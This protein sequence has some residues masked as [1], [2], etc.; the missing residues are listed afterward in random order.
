MNPFQAERPRYTLKT[1][2]ALYDGA[3][4]GRDHARGKLR[5]T[6]NN[7]ATPFAYGGEVL[8]VNDGRIFVKTDD[9]TVV[10]DVKPD[11]ILHAEVI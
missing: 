6:L 5:I 4:H 3:R 1:L 11:S 7:G 9:G 2:Q 8:L 10:S